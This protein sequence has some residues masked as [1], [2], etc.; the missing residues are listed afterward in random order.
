MNFIATFIKFLGGIF[1]SNGALDLGIALLTAGV[2][3]VMFTTTTTI[4]FG[5]I[6]RTMTPYAP[7]GFALMGLSSIFVSWGLFYS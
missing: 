5:L 1:I 6:T 4:L 2:G 7:L 3:L